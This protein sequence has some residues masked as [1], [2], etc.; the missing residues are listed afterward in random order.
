MVDGYKPSVA[1]LYDPTDGA[2][3]GFDKWAKDKYILIF[4]AEGEKDLAEV[5]SKAINELFQR[6]MELR[7]LIL[8]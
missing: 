1:R 2:Q 3:H 8:L 7:Q 5:T 4:T 6:E